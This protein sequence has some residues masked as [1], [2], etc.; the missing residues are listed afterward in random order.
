VAHPF[1]HFDGTVAAITI[2]DGK[3]NVLTPAVLAELDAA[4]S[5]AEQDDA[6][7]IIGGLYQGGRP[8]GCGSGRPERGA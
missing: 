1:H 5:R 2:D 6:V 4:L 3:V 7:V 8:A